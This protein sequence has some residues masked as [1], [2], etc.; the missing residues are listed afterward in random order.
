MVLSEICA[1]ALIY[2]VFSITHITI[3]TYKGLYNT[4]FAKVWVALVF[5]IV[6]NYLCSKGLGI[7]SWLIVFI[8]F[9]LMTLIIGIL[10]YM[11]GLNPATG[12]LNVYSSANKYRPIQ[13]PPPDYR[14]LARQKYYNGQNILNNIDNDLKYDTSPWSKRHDKHYK[15][16]K[17]DNSDDDKHDK[18]Y[19]DKKHHNKKHH[20]KK[21]DEH[22]NYRDK[23]GSKKYRHNRDRGNGE[24]DKISTYY[25]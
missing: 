16:D 17:Y 20:N 12:R 13:P 1:P 3:D 2:L 25:I 4:A 9:V 5:T 24:E 18:K 19:Y 11:F 21:Y 22:Y 8:P 14:K 23:G 7:I 10:L 6:L 15:Y